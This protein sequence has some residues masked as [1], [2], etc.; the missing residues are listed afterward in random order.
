MAWSRVFFQPLP[1]EIL[2]MLFPMLISHFVSCSL[3]TPCSKDQQ[4]YRW[5]S[6]RVLYQHPLPRPWIILIFQRTSSCNRTFCRSNL[7]RSVRLRICRCEA[8]QRDHKQATITATGGMSVSGIM[9]V[10]ND[11]NEQPPD[12]R[13]QMEPR[14]AEVSVWDM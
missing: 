13:S 3:N 2:H 7:T 8:Q 10:L 11:V 9:G 4:G 6:Y 5:L 12:F 14:K 1:V